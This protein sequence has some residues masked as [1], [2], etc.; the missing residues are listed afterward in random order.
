MSIRTTLIIIPPVNRREGIY[1]VIA[2]T[3]QRAGSVIACDPIDALVN[4]DNT[5]D[6]Q[7]WKEDF[8][9]YELC[10]LQQTA[11][12]QSELID[13]Y[14]AWYETQPKRSET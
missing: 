4:I 7:E 5:A 11:L 8:G 9:D 1:E 3:G 6:K 2:S 10:F 13:R 12:T 14:S